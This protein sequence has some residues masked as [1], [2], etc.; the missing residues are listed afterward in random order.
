[1]IYILGVRNSFLSISLV[2][3]KGLFFKIL[4]FKSFSE[5]QI[6]IIFFRGVKL[7]VKL[8]LSFVIRQIF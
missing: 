1:M 7:L 4:V 2:F 6:V 5:G 8:E 3:K